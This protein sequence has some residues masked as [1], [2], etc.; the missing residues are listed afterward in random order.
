MKTLHFVGDSLI[1]YFDWQYRFSACKVTN[2]GWAGETVSELPWLNKKTISSINPL[3][4]ELAKNKGIEYLDG[5]RI[6]TKNNKNVRYFL[7]DG[8]HI[9]DYGYS[10][11]AD[12]ITELIGVN[13]KKSTHGIRCQK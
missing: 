3:I 7:E 4:A 11:W 1:E 5:C 8:V 12:A 6:F 13:H 9:S 2:S 10:V